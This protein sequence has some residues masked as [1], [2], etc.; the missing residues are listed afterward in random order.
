MLQ[1]RFA[2]QEEDERF[3]IEFDSPQTAVEK[4]QVVSIDSNGDLIPFGSGGAS[5]FKLGL[6]ASLSYGDTIAYI[7]P[8][9]TIID[10]FSKPEKL[11]GSFGDF[12]YAST[13]TP[14]EITTN[15]AQGSDKLYFQFKDS[16]PTVV[17]AS[18]V[19]S[20][21]Q[22][23][24]TLI[25]NGVTSASGARTIS[26]IVS[27]IN[28]GTATHFVTATEPLGETVLK[29]YDSSLQPANGDIVMV[30]STDAGGNVQN[31]QVTISDGINSGTVTFS[32]SDGTFPGT[33]GA[34]LT[35]SATQMAQDIN[36][37]CSAN[38]IDIV[39]STEAN[40][41][42]N[43]NSLYPKLVLTLGSSGSGIT[44]TEVAADAATQTFQQAT[45]M[46]LTASATT[47]RTLILTRADGGD[48]MLTGT[49]TF[50]NSNGI[51]SS[52][53][54]SPALLVMVEDEEGSGVSSEGVSTNDDYNLN[55]NVTSS[56]GDTTGLTISNT[57][58][59]DSHV[60]IMVNG[61]EVS[62]AG[63]KLLTCYFSAD[64][65]TTARAIS[66]IV[67]GDTLY[68]NGSIA[69]YQL[70]ANDKINIIYEKTA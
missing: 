22:T 25:I 49:G 14:G 19:N 21:T 11:T 6:L 52:S 64:G 62:L 18:V 57:P 63:N 3:R 33:G 50:V 54:G 67:S 39:A 26:Q 59:N 34:Y 15:S 29:S 23:G 58:H 68:W 20:A 65:G 32:T 17:T 28:G 24:D 44:I 69:G 60:R 35:V 7:K 56:D 1:S 48:I 61:I 2:I 42:G 30:T 27:D 41:N 8:F 13:V 70:D 37:V 31:L 40:T 12:Y 51:V 43:N 45:A 36:T 16:V 9:N 4:G 55:P 53:S 5:D 66:N 47:D 10:D 38:S 46:P